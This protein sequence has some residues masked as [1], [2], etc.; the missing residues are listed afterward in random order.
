MS[1][2]PQFNQ[3]ESFFASDGCRRIMFFY[4]ECS[5]SDLENILASLF[6]LLTFFVNSL[7]IAVNHYNVTGV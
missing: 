4:Q 7:I 6:N 5:V 1:S 2:L 3:L